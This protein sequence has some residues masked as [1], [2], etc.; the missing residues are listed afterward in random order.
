MNIVFCI[1]G[2]TGT[3]KT[4]IMNQISD[5]YEQFNIHE[6][7]MYTTR[8]MREGESEGNPYHFVNDDF[9]YEKTDDII[10]KR[11]YDT[12][13]GKWIYGI[14]GSD[15]INSQK[16]FIINNCAIECYLNIKEGLKDKNTVVVPILLECDEYVR[17]KRALEREKEGNQDYKEMIRRFY[18]DEL[19]YDRV[20]INSIYHLN[21]NQSIDNIIHSIHTIFKYCIDCVEIIKDLNKMNIIHTPY[22]L[23]N[24]DKITIENSNNKY[25]DMCEMNELADKIYKMLQDPDFQPDSIFKKD[26]RDD[27]SLGFNRQFSKYTSAIEVDNGIPIHIQSS[28]PKDD[29]RILNSNEL[30][31]SLKSLNESMMK[32]KDNTIIDELN[33]SAKDLHHLNQK[34]IIKVYKKSNIFNKIKFKISK[35]FK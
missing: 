9:F 4:F 23:I 19:D 13:H 8:P 12:V 11:V 26:G 33:E 1:L 2:K 14:L 31:H 27:T 7:I 22:E 35:L 29:L 18:F 15:L 32:I 25:T 5:L 6:V 20:D 34:C 10:D 24:L 21:M 28:I 17:I 3:G 30:E 16:N